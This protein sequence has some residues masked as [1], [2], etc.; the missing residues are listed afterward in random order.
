[1]ISVLAVMSQYEIELF[2]AR[3]IDGKISAL[4]NKGG[5]CGGSSTYGYLI[6]PVD[7]R[8]VI[9]EKEAA[10]VRRIFNYFNEG[11]SSLQIA[12]ILNSEGIPTAY[13]TRIPV[14]ASKRATKGLPEKHYCFIDPDN[15]V[16]RASTINRLVKNPIYIGHRSK[17]I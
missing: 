4:K 14:A 5:V 6:S 15:L 1:M 8:L 2:V 9:D 10:V 12:D 11:K 17:K 13:A 7:K 16:W 3:G